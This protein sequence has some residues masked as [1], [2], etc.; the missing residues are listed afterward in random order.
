VL[1]AFVLLRDLASLDFLELSLDEALE[2]DGGEGDATTGRY[3][4]D[5]WLRERKRDA[6][7]LSTN[8]KE[9]T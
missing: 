8:S 9:K 3:C 1:K 5:F 2:E 4:D 7:I 6:H